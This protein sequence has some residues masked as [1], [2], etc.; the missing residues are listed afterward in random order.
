M[1]EAG[2]DVEPPSD[3]E[4]LIKTIMDRKAISEFRWTTVDEIVKKGGELKQVTREEYKEWFDTLSPRVKKRVNDAW[5]NPPGE[6]IDG[7]PAAMVYNGKI[8]V[9]GVG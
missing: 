6:E 7:V 2:Y 9:T 5:G 3:G 4:E 8:L 1:K